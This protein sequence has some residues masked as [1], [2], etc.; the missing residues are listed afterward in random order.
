MGRDKSQLLWLSGKTLAAWTANALRAAGWDPVFV[1]GPH[2]RKMLQ[3]NLREFTVVCNPTPERGKTGSVLAGALHWVDRSGALLLASVDQPRPFTVYRELRR[4]AD[5]ASN[6]LLVPDEQGHRGH[7][8]VVPPDLRA[9]L[10]SISDATQGL[11][12]LLNRF[13]D[14]TTLVPCSRDT[15]RWDLN[16][17]ADH[18][19]ALAWFQTAL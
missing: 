9:E 6:R 1:S 15:P 5:L 19:A 3:T 2:N 11:L 4:Q 18:E 7:P 12:G 13:R 14:R 16:K 8:V 17:P 10:L